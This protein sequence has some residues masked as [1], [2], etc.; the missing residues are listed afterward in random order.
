MRKVSSISSYLLIIYNYHFKWN[1]FLLVQTQE[2]HTKILTVNSHINQSKVDE[3]TNFF[4]QKKEI[5]TLR[6]FLCSG[7]MIISVTGHHTPGLIPTQNIPT[8]T[9]NTYMY[10]NTHPG[11]THQDQSIQNNKDENDKFKFNNSRTARCLNNIWLS[12][13]SVYFIKVP[14][15]IDKLLL[16]LHQ[17]HHCNKYR[18]KVTV[19]CY[20]GYISLIKWIV[21][22][23]TFSQ[24]QQ[25]IK[26]STGKIKWFEMFLKIWLLYF[27]W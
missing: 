4:K 27:L 23:F 9:L 22:Y 24:I 3:L 15:K 11:T 19:L 6:M 5:D 14:F 18:Y 16:N 13:S 17:Y 20:L 21:V 1:I 25:Y 7:D 10:D 12:I 8:R 26:I 2:S